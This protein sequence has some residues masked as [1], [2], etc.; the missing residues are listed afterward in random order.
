MV[1]FYVADALLY[2]TEATREQLREGHYIPLVG[3]GLLLAYEEEGEIFLKMLQGSGGTIYGV[4]EDGLWAN[5]VGGDPIDMGWPSLLDRDEAFIV[6]ASKTTIE[7]GTG[8]TG[9]SIAFSEEEYVVGARA[10]IEPNKASITVGETQVFRL[11]GLPVDQSV[12]V[13][14]TGAVTELIGEEIRV[15][16]TQWDEHIEVI[17]SIT[18]EAETYRISAILTPTRQV[19]DETPESP[20]PVEPAEPSTEKEEDI[21]YETTK[22]SVKALGASTPVMRKVSHRRRGPRES[23]KLN[24]F[25]IGVRHELN[26]LNEE[27]KR[28]KASM[29]TSG[30][31]EVDT[32]MVE[33][34]RVVFLEKP[35]GV[36]TLRLGV[37]PVSI[38]G[39]S[40]KFNGVSLNLSDY[41]VG[42]HGIMSLSDQYAKRSGRIEVELRYER[43]NE[44]RVRISMDELKRRARRLEERM[45]QLKEGINNG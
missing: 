34:E 12:F 29:T 5:E 43:E 13:E 10:V 35:K 40:V 4:E 8:G 20:V 45:C 31:E 6:S 22:T 42:E 23:E 32:M 38:K 7:I 9:K 24:A 14:A 27:E 2:P 1:R 18:G 44:S 28:L 21:E 19:D 26:Q 30:P 39:T 16:P 17:A 41:T 37:R 11:V 25:L 3:Q 36:R 15:T 33:D